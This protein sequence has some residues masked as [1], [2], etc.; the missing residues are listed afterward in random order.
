M[1]GVMMMMMIISRVDV[2]TPTT[3]RSEARVVCRCQE[4]SS[5]DSI[6]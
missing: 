4:P 2:A 5:Q 3:Y 1:Q 6:V